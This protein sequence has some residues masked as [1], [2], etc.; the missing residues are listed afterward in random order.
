[1]AN[2]VEKNKHFSLRANC[3]SPG[4]E[5]RPALPRGNLHLGRAKVRAKV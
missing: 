3:S 5:D 2:T 1:M 4:F